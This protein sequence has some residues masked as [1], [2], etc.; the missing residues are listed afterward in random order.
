MQLMVVYM[1]INFNNIDLSRDSFV[2]LDNDPTQQAHSPI[3][4]EDI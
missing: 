4:E 1:A 3:R 2:M